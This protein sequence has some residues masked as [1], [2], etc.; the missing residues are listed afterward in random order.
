MTRPAL[1]PAHSPAAAELTCRW[2]GHTHQRIALAPGERALCVECGSLLAKR[3]RFGADAALAFTLTGLVLIVPAMM[4]PLVTVDK[5]R[6]E[7]VGYLLSGVEALWQDGMRL[8][9]VWVLLCGTV[10][11]IILLGTLAGLLLPAK[12]GIAPAAESLLTRTATAVEHWSM[13]EVYVLAVLVAL[14]KLG[15]LVN[16]TVGPGL[17]CYGA[18]AMM[19]LSAWRSFEFGLPPPRAVAAAPAIP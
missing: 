12:F 15:T 1:S 19:I 6:A 3:G 8:L 7:R 5:I 2:C 13:P 9:S 14:T 10:A 4:L 11:P 17:W 16:V 18:M